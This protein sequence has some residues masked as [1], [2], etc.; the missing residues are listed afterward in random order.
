L[1]GDG[2]LNAW[3]SRLLD[4]VDSWREWKRR[5]KMSVDN[6]G[7][8]IDTWSTDTALQQKLGAV[9]DREELARVAVQAGSERGIRFTEKEFLTTIG[10]EHTAAGS[11]LSDDDLEGAAGGTMIGT[12]LG[13]EAVH[14][15]SS[16][17]GDILKMIERLPP[18][19]PP[20]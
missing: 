18:S 4:H 7:R 19:K 15:S 10:R 12:S 6:V 1:T 11:E 13:H 17:W 14:A 8:F 3:Y 9:R 20:G 2:P 5:T 16:F